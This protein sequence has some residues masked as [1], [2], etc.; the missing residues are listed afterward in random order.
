MVIFQ[1]SLILKSNKNG[2]IRGYISLHKSFQNIW[3]K[4]EWI[5]LFGERCDI[6]VNIF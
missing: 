5:K 1:E 2:A 3:L 6:D 4:Q